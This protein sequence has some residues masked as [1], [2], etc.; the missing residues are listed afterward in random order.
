N[1]LVNLDALATPLAEGDYQIR[2]KAVLANGATLTTPLSAMKVLAGIETKGTF[3]V[4]TQAYAAVNGKGAVFFGGGGTDTLNLG[5]GRDQV[6]SFDG[7]PLDQFKNK[8]NSVTSQAIYHGSAF[9][10]L[11]FKDGRE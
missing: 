2:V 11:R 10:Y 3:K 1:L 4:D 8:A 6:V 7:Q 5:L 9:D